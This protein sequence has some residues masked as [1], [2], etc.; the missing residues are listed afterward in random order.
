MIQWLSLNR[1]QKKFQKDALRDEISHFRRNHETPPQRSSLMVFHPESETKKVL[2]FPIMERRRESRDDLIIP[3]PRQK[4]IIPIMGRGLQTI[5]MKKLVQWYHVPFMDGYPD[6]HTSYNCPPGVWDELSRGKIERG[7]KRHY[8][9]VN[10]EAKAT[11]EGSFVK[12]HLTMGK[13]QAFSFGQGKWAT[14]PQ[15]NWNPFLMDLKCCICRQQDLERH[16]KEAKKK[17]KVGLGFAKASTT[18][19]PRLFPQTHSLKTDPSQAR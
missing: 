15:G 19:C 17:T 4:L 14:M 3:I 1:Q 2:W 7:K 6:R 5:Q 11:W 16:E 8:E 13:A 10:R 12:A 9:W 18:Q